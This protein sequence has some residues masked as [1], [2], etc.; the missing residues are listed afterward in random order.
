MIPQLV[1]L[2]VDGADRR[3]LAGRVPLLLNQLLA[4]GGSTEPGIEALRLEP[5]VGLALAVH[6]G[7]DVIQQVRQPLFGPQSA[8]EREGVEANDAALQLMQPL[9]DGVPVP[10]QLTLG[11]PLAAPAKELD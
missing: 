9:A 8:S 1:Q 2:V 4:D 7:S 10:A 5:R 6:D 11:T 3:H